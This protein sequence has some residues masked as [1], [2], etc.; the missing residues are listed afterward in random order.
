MFGDGLERLKVRRAGCPEKCT[1]ENKCV[2][3]N[4]HPLSRDGKHT[5]SSKMCGVFKFC[6]VRAAKLRV[7]LCVLYLQRPALLKEKGNCVSTPGVP[8]QE[9]R[10][11]TLIMHFSFWSFILLNDLVWMFLKLGSQIFSKHLLY[12]LLS[13]NLTASESTLVKRETW[14]PKNGKIC[15]FLRTVIPYP[16][17]TG[18]KVSVILTYAW[19]DLLLLSVPI[20]KVLDWS[21]PSEVL[22]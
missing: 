14:F 8:T 11:S 7:L 20:W 10:V 1:S 6:N 2:K 9:G 19:R 21:L 13:A 17:P 4:W 5:M 12:P 15:L 22:Q 3:T 18:A 16:S